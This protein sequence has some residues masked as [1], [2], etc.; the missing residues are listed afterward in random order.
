MAGFPEIGNDIVEKVLYDPETSHVII[1][2][3]QYFSKIEPEVWNFEVGG[4]KVCERW[5]RERNGRK[6]NSDDQTEFM[7]IVGSFKETLRL[8]QEL[9]SLFPQIEKDVASLIQTTEQQK[10]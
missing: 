2:P 7:R 3:K 6:L 4:Y 10:L 5:L 8:Q 1:N 9:D